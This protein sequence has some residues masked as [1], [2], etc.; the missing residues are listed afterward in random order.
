MTTSRMPVIWRPCAALLKHY[1]LLSLGHDSTSVNTNFQT[2]IE[3]FEEFE[4]QP[5]AMLYFFICH[6]LSN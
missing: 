5:I 1:T 3:M 2:I 4:D 6:Q